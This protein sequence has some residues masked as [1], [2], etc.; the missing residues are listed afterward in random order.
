MVEMDG[1]INRQID[2]GETNARYIQE[3]QSLALICQLGWNLAEDISFA[4]T[5]LGIVFFDNESD[6][7]ESGL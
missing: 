6:V 2:A 1:A 3:I 5:N 4:Y 7:E